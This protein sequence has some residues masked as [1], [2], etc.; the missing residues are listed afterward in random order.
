MKK[1]TEKKAPSCKFYIVKADGMPCGR[2]Q[3]YGKKCGKFL[4]ISEPVCHFRTNKAAARA[5]KNTKKFK[6]MLIGS[7]IY[8]WPQIQWLLKIK[9]YTVETVIIAFA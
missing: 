3:W 9:A 7:V 4:S 6:E 8:D 2:S 1:S 5:I